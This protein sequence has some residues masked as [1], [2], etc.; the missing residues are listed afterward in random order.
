M[1]VVDIFNQVVPVQIG[2]SSLAWVCSAIYGSPTLS[3]QELL[4]GHLAELRRRI[5][6]PWM[7][8]VDFNEVL[9]PSEV[10][11]GEF[12]LAQAN[13]FAR[14]MENCELMDIGM[15]GNKFT[16]CHIIQGR[17]QMVKRLDKVLVDILWRCG[18]QKLMWRLSIE[19]ILIII[20]FCCDMV[21]WVLL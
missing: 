7:L 4:W 19:C 15:V 18:F 16:W 9:L 14:V 12:S 21:M 20:R 17:R 6:L 10:K 2:S 5:L 11:G 13:H 8:I 1:I 3:L